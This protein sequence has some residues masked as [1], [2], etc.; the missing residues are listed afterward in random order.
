VRR[1]LG[2]LTVAAALAAA[3]AGCG[4]SEDRTPVAHV[5]ATTITREQLDRTVEHFREEASRDGKP[6]ADTPAARRHLLGLLVYRARLEAGAAALGITI[7]NDAVEQRLES[8]GGGEG[9]DGDAKA[10]LASSVRAQLLTEAVY[11][12][13]AARVHV[14]DPQRAQAQ[15]NAALERW[16]AVLAARYPVR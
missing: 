9:E 4:G 10:F 11:R 16:T 7:P 15:R 12:K 1:T 6:F 2:V 8:A 5:G 14:S 3:A 13:L